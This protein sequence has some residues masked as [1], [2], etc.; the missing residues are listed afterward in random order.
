MVISPELLQKIK[1]L[2]KEL[3]FSTYNALLNYAVLE[4]TSEGL[5]PPAEYESV[6]VKLGTRPAL[7]TGRSGDGKTTVVKELLSQFQGNV[8][9]L[10]VNDE[11]KD[12][13]QLDLGEFFGLKWGKPDQRVRFVSHA[14]T[15][16]SK[17][18]AATIFSHLNYVKNGG[19]L[20]DWTIVIEEAHRFSADVNLRALLI[21]AR[22]FVRKLLLVTTDWRVYEGIARVFKPAPWE[23][24]PPAAPL[25]AK[26][27]GFSQPQTQG[28][29]TGQSAASQP[30]SSPA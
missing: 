3:G 10:D 19:E 29:D 24:I 30:G 20:K 27:E 21:E 22:K 9:L 17:A 2:K 14:N 18:E 26:S 7:I 5:I 12:L 11:Y 16:I 23:L 15:E 1:H 4:L 8:F 13:R 25:A 28:S 6:F